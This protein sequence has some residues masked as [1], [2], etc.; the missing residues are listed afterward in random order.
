M[1]EVEKMLKD[2]KDSIDKLEVPK[3][4][5]N[6]LRSALKYRRKNKNIKNK[7]YLKVAS[8]AILVFLIGYNMNTLGFYGKKIIGY[9]NVMTDTLKKLNDTGMGQNINKSYTFKNGVTLFLDGAMMDEDSIV[10]F[11][12]IKDNR[13]NIENIDIQ[14][15]SLVYENQ[16][17]MKSSSGKINYNKTEIN[18]NGKFKVPHSLKKELKFSLILKEGTYEECG[19]IVFNLDKN[20]AIGNIFKKGIN[21]SI[22][23]DKGKVKVT[24]VEASLMETKIKGNFRN[25]FELFKDEIGEKG[26]RI[27]DMDL[28][29]IADGKEI[30]CKSKEFKTGI[31]G[32]K[33]KME[34]DALDRKTKNVALKLVGIHANYKVNENIKLEKSQKENI[35]KIQGQKIK[36]DKIYEKDKETY[37]R[38]IT[39]EDVI[40]SKVYLIADGKKINLKETIL[41]K[42]NKEK[43]GSVSHTRTLKFEGSGKNLNLQI[44]GIKYKKTYNKIINIDIN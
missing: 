3:E 1:N 28:R 22:N 21:E 30:Q 35:I 8:I 25:I 16:N 38:I 2:K 29:L 33:F 27:I 24:S 20:K 12:R 11:Y 41:S 23:I 32:M 37:I 39:K 42:K 14:G 36:I 6:K 18:Y 40:L 17:L 26:F 10:I 5:E 15:P 43:D 4:L 13:G 44:K 7:R 31:S 19:N 9:D 34:Y